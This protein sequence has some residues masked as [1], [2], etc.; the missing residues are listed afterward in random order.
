LRAAFS[1]VSTASAPEFISSAM[2]MPDRS[3]S[4]RSSS[5]NWS[6]R[7]AREVSVTRCAWSTQACTIRGWQ[8]P[9]LT[10]E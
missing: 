1:A 3:C 10:A 5:G 4:C 6:L 7:N 8:W 9:W 2:S